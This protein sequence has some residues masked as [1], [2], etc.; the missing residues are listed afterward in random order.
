VTDSAEGIYMEGFAELLALG[1][2]LLQLK[3]EL[4]DLG[5]LRHRLCSSLFEV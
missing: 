5:A 4:L 2:Q 3:L 1:S